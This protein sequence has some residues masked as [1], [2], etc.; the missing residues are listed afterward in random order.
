MTI[1]DPRPEVVDLLVSLFDARVLTGGTDDRLGT[2]EDWSTGAERR[3]ALE[4]VAGRLRSEFARYRA[5]ADQQDAA[6]ADRL[7]IRPD[8]DQWLRGIGLAP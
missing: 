2:R 6:E 7:G 1:P 3:A 4:V 5:A 8:V